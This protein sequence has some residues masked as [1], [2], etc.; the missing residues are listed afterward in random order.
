MKR[1]FAV[2]NTPNPPQRRNTPPFRTISTHF[3]ASPEYQ[4]QPRG[5]D[6]SGYSHSMSPSM[7]HVPEVSDLDRREAT[8]IFY[9]LYFAEH[10]MVDHLHQGSHA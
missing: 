3:S 7:A 5:T 10:I 1:D 2:S 6:M 8:Y 9:I 4:C